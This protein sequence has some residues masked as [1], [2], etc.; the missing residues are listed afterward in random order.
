MGKFNYIAA[1]VCTICVFFTCFMLLT[2]VE[3]KSDVGQL[4]YRRYAFMSYL[5]IMG[6]EG[7]AQSKYFVQAAQRLGKS[8][9]RHVPGKERIQ[10]D[11]VL[12]IT[13]PYGLL[14]SDSMLLLRRVGWLLI[15]VDPLYGMPSN[16]LYLLQNHYTHTAQ[17]TKLHL[18]TFERYEHILYLDSDML[19]VR[20]IMPAVSNYYNTTSNILGVAHNRPRDDFFNSEGSYTFNAGLMFIT[21]SKLEF[22]KMRKAIFSLKY[23][24]SLQEQAFLQVYWTNRTFL[25]PAEINQF[26]DG[27]TKECMVMHFISILKPW[28]ICPYY[29]KYKE[30]CKE[31]DSY[32]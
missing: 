13:D 14:N 28:F 10:Y 18:W 22:I 11:M 1:L 8:W 17:F 27:I 23:D 26:V 5:S 19:I 12:L 15:K 6:I 9:I 21:P 32:Q 16:S 7:I 20:N 31:W 29:S 30:A 2:K 24:V 25:M 4:Y 3:L